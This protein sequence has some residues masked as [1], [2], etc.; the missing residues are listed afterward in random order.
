MNAVKEGVI[1]QKQFKSITEPEEEKPKAAKTSQEQIVDELDYLELML[2][3]N[4]A[5]DKAKEILQRIAESYL[6]AIQDATTPVNIADVPSE[7][8]VS[9]SETDSANFIKNLNEVIKEL[10]EVK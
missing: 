7:Q 3:E 9:D 4:G 1:T 2:Q 10:L 6:D 8:T 5:N